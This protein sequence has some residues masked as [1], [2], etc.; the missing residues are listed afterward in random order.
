MKY[1]IQYYHDSNRSRH[2]PDAIAVQRKG[3]VH[4]SRQFHRAGPDENGI[5]ECGI[6]AE[7][8]RSFRSKYQPHVGMKQI[9][10]LATK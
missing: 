5:I 1:T 4:I 3:G 6:T 8:I 2:T 10:K 7:Y 9:A